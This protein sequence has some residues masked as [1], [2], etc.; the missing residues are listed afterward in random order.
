MATF[1]IG[2]KRVTSSIQLLRQEADDLDPGT[3]QEQIE[4]AAARFTQLALHHH[5]RLEDRDGRHEPQGIL[6]DGVS[7]ST[8]FGLTE[9]DGDDRRGIDDHQ[10]GRPRSS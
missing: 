1:A 5:G 9:Q 3:V 6:V 8:C 7:E 4:L 10:R 2:A